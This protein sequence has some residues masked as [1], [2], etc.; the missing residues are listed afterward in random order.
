MPDRDSRPWRSF[1]S[2]PGR[3]PGLARLPGR[4]LPVPDPA[5][6]VV[7]RPP[8][9]DASLARIPAA[10]VAERGGWV[11]IGCGGQLC[12]ALEQ[13]R[14]RLHRPGRHQP[15]RHRDV[16]VCRPAHGA[17]RCDRLHQAPGNGLVRPPAGLSLSP[18]RQRCAELSRYLARIGARHMVVV[19]RDAAL[20]RRPRSRAVSIP[21]G[22]RRTQRTPA[23]GRI[24]QPGLP[25][26]RDREAASRNGWWV[27]SRFCGLSRCRLGRSPTSFTDNEYGERPA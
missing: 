12:P 16:R 26:V 15:Q 20:G 22:F 17:G 9:A 11:G 27:H 13:S 5:A 6:V 3:N 2:L 7:L 19:Q 18:G 24:R 8:G 25:G 23:A 21:A 1:P 4:T 14:S 10:A